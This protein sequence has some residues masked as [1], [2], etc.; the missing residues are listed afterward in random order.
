MEL[1]LVIR[2]LLGRKRLLAVGVIIALAAAVLSTHRLQGFMLKPKSLQYSAA[3]TQVFIDSP[4]TVLGNVNPATTQ[5]TTVATL[6]AN[7]MTSPTMLDLIAKKVG[8]SGNQLEASGPTSSLPRAIVEP[9]AVQRNVEL[10]GETTPYRLDYSNNPNLPI[11]GIATQAPT[12]QQAIGLA[13]AAA[14]G[15]A[16]YVTNLQDQ[17]GVPSHQRVIIRE[18]GQAHGHVVNGGTSKKLAFMAFVAVFFLWCVLLLGS[19]RFRKSWQQSGALY[20]A[21]HEPGGGVVAHN[22]ARHGPERTD[23]MDGLAYA[24]LEPLGPDAI[25]KVGHDSEAATKSARRSLLGPS[26]LTHTGSARTRD[27]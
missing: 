8:L 25:T 13:N 12:T 26:R 20:A 22:A 9:T 24:D 18:L 5:L 16:Q 15:L 14:S 23:G 3:S 10:T 17:S 27:D 11:V 7:F 2:E 6:D 1:A 21:E 4:S 19:R